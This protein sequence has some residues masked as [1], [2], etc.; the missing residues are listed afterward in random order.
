MTS[1]HEK[2]PEILYKYLDVDG[3]LKMTSKGT[4]KFSHPTSF[5]DPFEGAHELFPASAVSPDQFRPLIEAEYSKP[6]A[7]IPLPSLRSRRDFILNGRRVW[8]TMSEV[9]RDKWITDVTNTVVRAIEE[10]HLQG[11]TSF[12]ETTRAFRCL[13]MSE[14]NDN[15]LMWAHY[16]DQHRGVVVG[17]DS[18][19]LIDHRLFVANPYK[20]TY[21]NDKPFVYD[22]RDLFNVVVSGGT[23]PRPRTDMLLRKS[24]CW[25]YEREWRYIH[26][27]PQHYDPIR[28]LTTPK[29]SISSVY[30]GVRMSEADRKQVLE[31]VSRLDYPVECFEM[32]LKMSQYGL[33]A[34][35]VGQKVLRL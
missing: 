12:R 33:Q 3:F 30:L 34:V 6:I 27:D 14:S 11:I 5:N 1:G 15:E 32:C 13:C 35:P 23:L 24:S 20:V 2:P 8:W 19:K 22:F 18:F 31:A 7:D 9:E 29:G 26:F 10:L 16:S 17:L 21:S 4:L 28:F 25:S